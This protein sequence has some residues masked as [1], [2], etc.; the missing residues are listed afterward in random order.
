MR[1]ET[2]G[3]VLGISPFDTLDE[4]RRLANDST[5]GLAGFVFTK[6][7][8]T[9]LALGNALEVGQVW[10]NDIQRST[11]YAPFGGRWR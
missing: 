7:L 1:E 5:M 11:P 4:A 2:F 3:P 8:S 9:G 6:D 10:L